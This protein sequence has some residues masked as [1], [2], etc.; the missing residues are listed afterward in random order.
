MGANR[1]ITPSI[2]IETHLGGRS[3]Q[4]DESLVITRFLTLSDKSIHLLAVFD[5]H[6]SEGHKASKAAK[7]QFPKVLE[8]MQ[9]ALLAD[10]LGALKTAFHTVNDNLL[11]D[12]SWDS[13]MSGTTAV[14]AL[15][16]DTILHVAH[17]GDS[18]LVIVKREGGAW[19]GVAVT[20][21]HNCEHQAEKDRV[22]A[23]GGRVEQL[24]IDGKYDGP[25]R[26]FKGSLPYPG[27]T[28]TRSLGDAAA[29]RIGVICDPAVKTIT[30]DDTVKYIILGTDGLWD[31]IS[32]EK[33]VAAVSV[34]KDASTS[35]SALLKMGLQGLASKKI[36][37]NLTHV[38]CCYPVLP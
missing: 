38:V 18:R 26:I 12:Q 5:G 37:D 6:G 10:P 3:V 14:L 13:Y 27:I 34:C 16:M 8:T 2:V 33:C 22:I 28:V 35:A 23:A 31:G 36:D 4:Q 24:S 20:E 25:E 21:D 30:L 29:Q 15:I 32:L 19:S 9:D 11:N 1:I 17:V 7:E